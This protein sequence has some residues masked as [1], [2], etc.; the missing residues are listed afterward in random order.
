MHTFERKSVHQ[1]VTEL[2]YLK[3]SI[4]L[5]CL[6]SIKTGN[7]RVVLHIAC[8]WVHFLLQFAPQC[9][10]KEIMAVFEYII[11]HRGWY[12]L[13]VVW[14][15]R[16]VAPRFELRGLLIVALSMNRR[17]LFRNTIPSCR[18]HA[19]ESF[20]TSFKHP[21]TFLLCS[22]QSQNLND[23]FIASIMFVLEEKFAAQDRISEYFLF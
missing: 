12:N 8:Y 6:S 19:P 1:N 13:H 10:I 14:I 18:K 4:G 3:Q 15:V 23:M 17:V 20:P 9:V 16:K 5:Q 2:L 7:S 21:L 11:G 22:D